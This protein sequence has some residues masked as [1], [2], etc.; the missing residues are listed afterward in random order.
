MHK[1]RRES[2]GELGERWLRE[3]RRLSAKEE[4]KEGCMMFVRQVISRIP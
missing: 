1:G 4:G 3:G 2:Q